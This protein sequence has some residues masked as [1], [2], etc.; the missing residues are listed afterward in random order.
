MS[1]NCL[2]DWKLNKM[3]KSKT[4]PTPYPY[5]D[6]PPYNDPHPPPP[7]RRPPVRSAPRGVEVSQCTKYLLFFINVFFWLIGAFL[8]G[9]GIWGLVSKNGGS[10]S[11]LA[12]DLGIILDPM[13]AFIISGAV[14]FILGFFG[15]IGSLRENTCMIKFFTYFL[16]LIF[17]A[18]ITIGVLAYVY[19][20]QLFG[21][22][23]SWFDKTIVLYL[24]D[25]DKQFIMD[26]L[27]ESLRCCGSISPYDW[28]TN[29]YYNCSSIARSACSVPFSCCLPEEGVINYQCG[30]D[31][32]SLSD[33]AMKEVIYTYGCADAMRDWFITNAII[34]GCCVGALI[35]FQCVTICLGRSLISDIQEVKSY[36]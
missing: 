8:L 3:G 6:P 18:E 10:V 36:W 35:L 20:D 22:L 19:Q 26:G 27:Q 23:E 21:L 7:S 31:V 34:L 4:T 15:C 2:A 33:E 11:A 28:E 30:F 5:D 32:L 16:I 29:P 1:F 9:F 17:L 24:D 14:I 25:P 13:F 12:D